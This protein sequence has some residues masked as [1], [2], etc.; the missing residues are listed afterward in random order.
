MPAKHEES[1]LEL[2]LTDYLSFKI[3]II[4]AVNNC[5][6]K[7]W[8]FKQRFTEIKYF[9]GSDALTFT[10]PEAI[11]VHNCRSVENQPII[12]ESIYSSLSKT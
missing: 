6:I 1:Y 5:T 9:I 3:P 11:P 10:I 12:V 4:S 2:T 8:T 7:A